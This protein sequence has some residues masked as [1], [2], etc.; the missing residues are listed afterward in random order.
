MIKIFFWGFFVF[1]LHCDCDHGCFCLSY[2]IFNVK[3]SYLVSKSLTDITETCVL[4]SL[5]YRS[6]R[7]L[8]IGG[9]GGGNLD[10]GNLYSVKNNARNCLHPFFW[11]HGLHLSQYVIPSSVVFNNWVTTNQ[12][13]PQKHGKTLLDM[14]IHELY[15]ATCVFFSITS[16][17]VAFLPRWP[18]DYRI[19]LPINRSREEAKMLFGFFYTLTA[20]SME[21]WRCFTAV[22]RVR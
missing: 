2:R 6:P 13:N 11:R 3:T 17:R 7:I 19:W 12:K 4:L 18:S 22:W 5:E 8:R 15:R 20:Q 1:L 9:Q 21:V 16:F 10:S 14:I